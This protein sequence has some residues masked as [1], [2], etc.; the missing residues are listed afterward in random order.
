MPYRMLSDFHNQQTTKKPGSVHAMYLVSG[1]QVA[2]PSSDLNGTSDD[3][4]IDDTPMQSS[5]FMSSSM[6]QQEEE[7]EM[8]PILK[9]ITLVREEQL[10][11]MHIS[12]SLNNYTTTG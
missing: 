2:K 5:P 8:T 4:H 11:R 1:A 7:D 3:Q 12:F 9:V 10:E 6:P